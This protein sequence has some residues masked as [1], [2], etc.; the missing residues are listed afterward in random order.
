MEITSLRSKNLDNHLN[1]NE[2]D[3][4]NLGNYTMGFNALEE[5]LHL[6]SA[7]FQKLLDVV[8]RSNQ[9]L[10]PT[11]IHSLYSD[12]MSK[13]ISLDIPISAV[14]EYKALL[15]P[16]LPR[17]I[18]VISAK[19]IG[20]EGQE[21]AVPHSLSLKN[22][23]QWTVMVYLNGD[24]ELE[25]AALRDFL[26]MSKI[27]STDDVNIVVLLD[28]IPNSSSWDFDGYSTDYDDWTGTQAGLVSLGDLPFST[29]G[30]YWG[31]M[32]LGDPNSLIDFVD[33]ATYAFP[34][35]NYALVVWNHGDGWEG[36]SFDES[37]GGDGLTLQEI[38]YALSSIPA[39][40]DLF[41]YDAC[42]MGMIECA[43]EVGD[44][45]S[46]FVA[47]EAI[48]PGSGFPYD[49]ILAA[50]VSQPNM[51]PTQLGNQIVSDYGTY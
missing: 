42:L 8:N 34:A 13:E 21:F 49:E 36:S 22:P 35:N 28:R 14:S 7:D 19:Q 47:S 10:R 39:E 29:W 30:N 16:L 12:L 11:N 24:N 38:N 5:N 6:D 51:S 43:Y 20:Q 46:I 50:L 15:R 41:S 18:E 2:G 37:S 45:A 31:E 1:T 40:I 27:G 23:A 44:H 48:V 25:Q 26:E 4:T 33:A 9:T 17:N 3:K 32:N